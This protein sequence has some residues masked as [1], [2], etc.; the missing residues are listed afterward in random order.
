MTIDKDKLKRQISAYQKKRPKYKK[1]AGL[2]EEI[3]TKACKLYAPNAIV[4][5]RAKTLPSYAEKAVRKEAVYAD[6]INQFNDLCG[7]RIITHMPS[8]VYNFSEFI[9]DNFTINDAKS[10]DVRERLR[11]NEFGYRSVHYIVILTTK[12]ILGVPIPRE[13]RGMRA[14]IQVRTLLQHMWANIAHDRVYKTKI[15]VPQKWI[16]ESARLAALMESAD[17]SYERMALN[18][19]LYNTHYGA[20]MSKDVIEREIE[21]L[22]TLISNEKNEQLKSTHALKLARLYKLMGNYNGM[23]ETLESPDK[24]LGTE[25]LEQIYMELGFAECQLYRN[26]VKCTAFRKGRE[27]L[28]EI[29]QPLK[30]RTPVTESSLAKKDITRKDIIRARALNLL[31]GTYQGYKKY[32]SNIRDLYYQAYLLDSK[33]PHHLSAFLEYEMSYRQDP[34]LI[35]LMHSAITSAIETCRQYIQV[36]IEIPDAYFTMGRLWLLLGDAYESLNAFAKGVDLC[37]SHNATVPGTFFRDEIESLHRMQGGKQPT[38][39][40]QW[41]ITLL[42][43]ADKLY[44]EDNTRDVVLDDI[45][46]RSKKFKTP[47][48]IVAG[49]AALMDINKKEEYR[50]YLLNGFEDFTGSIISGGTKE[51]I[52]G[53]IGQVMTTLRDTN[54]VDC[55]LI[56][57]LPKGK[58]P[59]DAVIDRENY[60]MFVR[61]SNKGFSPEQPLQNWVDIVAAGINPSDVRLLGINGGKIAGFE[62]RLALALGAKVGLIESGGRESSELPFDENWGNHERLMIL[63][64][65]AM[66]IKA[67]LNWETSNIMSD[68]QI[69]RNA[70]IVYETYY[71]INMKPWGDLSED[72]KWSNMHQVMYMTVIL[73]AVG[74]GVRPKEKGKIKFPKIKDSDFEKMAEMEHGRWNT[75]R[76][77]RGWSY[78]QNKDATNKISPYIVPWND[79]PEK[80]KEY[81][82]VPVKNFPELLAK[83]GFEVYQLKKE[84]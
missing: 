45:V 48:L 68:D 26:N 66:T 38:E 59:S 29:A 84:K 77:G 40:Y 57:Y 15:K 2:I 79:L 71:K 80:I 58:L 82:R 75:E 10:Q 81:D 33:N 41:V 3:L 60:D 28:E 34:S 46:C 61:T 7:A 63:P 13:L 49:G 14:E 72:E 74:Y 76:L 32:E 44:N 35:S 73:N 20:L 42:R 43:L 65:D 70:K 37:L 21:I 27:R 9:R 36:G 23:I 67:F 8:E 24:N 50:S 83:A 30:K 53:L 17:H 11:V 4:Q 52:P 6:P 47:I 62:F 1:L 31:A 39:S 55:E 25:I 18:I 19:D 78:G 22:L 5:A 12:T 54:S 64:R 16:R 56:G 51:G 69:I